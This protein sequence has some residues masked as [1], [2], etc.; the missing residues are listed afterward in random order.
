VNPFNPPTRGVPDRVW[1]FFASLISES[2]WVGSLNDQ[3]VV[4]WAGLG[5]V[6]HFDSSSKN[7]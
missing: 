3:P 1:I 5:W 6:T 4:G 7:S 2:G